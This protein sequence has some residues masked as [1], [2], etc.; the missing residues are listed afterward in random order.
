LLLG[1]V[2]FQYQFSIGPVYSVTLASIQRYSIKFKEWIWKLKTHLYYLAN[3]LS[4][5]A[6]SVFLFL[7]NRNDLHYTDDYLPFFHQMAKNRLL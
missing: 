2:Y 1:S 5:F 7:K 4:F 6:I 3:D